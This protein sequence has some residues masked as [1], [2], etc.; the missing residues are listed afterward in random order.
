M[1]NGSLLLRFQSHAYDTFVTVIRSKA[2][3]LMATQMSYAPL[4]RTVEMGH[5]C[6][7][8]LTYEPRRS[9]MHARDYRAYL[10]RA[11]LL[12]NRAV[13]N[14]LDTCCQQLAHFR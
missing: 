3:A 8:R 1:Q 7:M 10:M 5:I 11:S 14:H 13:P 4:L 2:A 6:I 9:E 12:N